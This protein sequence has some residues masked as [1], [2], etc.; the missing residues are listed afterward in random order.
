MTQP[1]S[2]TDA[3]IADHDV[4]AFRGPVAEIVGNPSSGG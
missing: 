3:D 2:V 1:G 4:H